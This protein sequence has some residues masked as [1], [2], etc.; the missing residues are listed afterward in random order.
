MRPTMK[1][2]I[3]ALASSVLVCLFFASGVHGAFADTAR[4]EQTEQPALYIWSTTDSTMVTDAE[5]AGVY[6]EAEKSLLKQVRDGLASKGIKVD[7]VASEKEIAAD[8]TRYTLVMKLDKIELGGKRPFGRTA[9]IKVVYAL[10]NQDRFEFIRRSDEE[11]SV[12][13]W[14]NCID[15]ISK[16]VVE[17]VS[18]DLA[19][20]AAPD[21]PAEKNDKATP[22]PA[23]PSSEAGP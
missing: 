7:V 18:S 23:G 12:Q 6:R 15:A 17:K 13:K 1:F 22:V 2:K 16:Q 14:Q 10:Q 5:L 19:K 4:P 9:K 8:P 21:I 3:R 20:R 11:T